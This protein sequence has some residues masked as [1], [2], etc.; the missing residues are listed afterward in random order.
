METWTVFVFVSGQEQ[1][2][3]SYEHDDEHPVCIKSGKYF[4]WIRTFHLFKKDF[5]SYS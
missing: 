1:V 5:A 3:G 2:A 4:D